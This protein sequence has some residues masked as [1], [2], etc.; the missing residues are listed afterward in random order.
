MQMFD[1]M[2]LFDRL[3]AELDR[4]RQELERSRAR[5]M[6]VEEKPHSWKFGTLFRYY[7]TPSIRCPY[8]GEMFQHTASWLLRYDR[9]SGSWGIADVAWDQLRIERGFADTWY[10]V[11]PHMYVDGH[12]ICMGQADSIDQ[13]M[14]WGLN[15]DSPA[16]CSVKE[17]LARVT[18]H[19]CKA[20][21]E[22]KKSKGEEW[23]VLTPRERTY[24]PTGF[25]GRY[26]RA[27]ATGILEVPPSVE[28]NDEEDEENWEDDEDTVFCV[29]CDEM[30]EVSV[31][32]ASPD[33]DWMCD[34]CYFEYYQFCAKCGEVVRLQRDVVLEV[35]SGEQWCLYCYTREYDECNGCGEV[36]RLEELTSTSD[37]LNFC[38]E[39]YQEQV[40]VCDDCWMDLYKR[41]L[42]PTDSDEQV[43][44]GCLNRRQAEKETQ[45][46]NF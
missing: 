18:D 37:G 32:N 6:V 38:P 2:E 3:V 21:A 44:A 13:V 30:L 7:P 42:F 25:E 12:R 35:P 24:C 45:D 8:C 43:C 16:S 34:D 46:G 9:G 27:M 11:F 31:A 4:E 29:E 20:V 40:A 1:R 19:E 39:C 41:D 23:L 14:L 17:W 36:T 28:G 33:G 10:W 5:R 15:P 22:F 26:A